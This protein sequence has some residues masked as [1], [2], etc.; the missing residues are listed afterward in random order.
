M[1][2]VIPLANWLC[3]EEPDPRGGEEMLLYNCLRI[4]SSITYWGLLLSNTGVQGGARAGQ[5]LRILLQL[6]RSFVVDPF[7]DLK[8]PL[9]RKQRM[10]W[11][12]REGFPSLSPGSLT[13]AGCCGQPGLASKGT[14]GE[15]ADFTLY[16]YLLINW[17]TKLCVRW[18]WIIT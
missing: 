15:V 1:D 17:D 3:S 4:R 12:T 18:D 6:P 14:L 5:L 11:L 10:N 2:G 16:L 13:R 9:A 7:T 8:S